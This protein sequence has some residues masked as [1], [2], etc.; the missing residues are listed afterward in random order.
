M[1]SSTRA[2]GSA[3]SLSPS[4]D[5][6]STTRSVASTKFKGCRWPRK[7]PRATEN[8]GLRHER[9]VGRLGALLT[10]ARLERHL[11]PLG[12]RLEAVTGHVA[13]M[14]E[15]VLGPL[16]RGDEPVPL[17]IVEPLDG[18]FCHGNTPPL[19]ISRTRREGAH[20]AD[21]TRSSSPPP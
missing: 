12:E 4:S 8:P 14:H 13:V 20:S 17:R 9:D 21:R 6:D 15:K 10:L 5:F 11:R 18:S 7:R 3:I 2:G 19:P 16:G 1:S